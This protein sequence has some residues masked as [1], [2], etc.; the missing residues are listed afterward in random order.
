MDSVCNAPYIKFVN[1]YHANAPF[2][3]AQSVGWSNATMEELA[4][5]HPD[6]VNLFRAD[7]GIV[8]IHLGRVLH[9]YDPK[10]CPTEP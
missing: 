8:A 10:N 7:C 4:A 6:A 9:I 3:I 2:L 5:A 1:G